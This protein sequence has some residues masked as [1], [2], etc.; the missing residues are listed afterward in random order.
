MGLG[1]AVKMSGK[2]RIV[3]VTFCM[4]FWDAMSFGVGGGCSLEVGVIC[5]ASAIPAKNSK[6]N[7]VFSEY[8][9]TYA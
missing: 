9:S 7:N 1:E 8:M 6:L 3:A 4:L 5:H 2:W